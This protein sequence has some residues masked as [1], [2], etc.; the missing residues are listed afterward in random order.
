[1]RAVFHP[2]ASMVSVV[3]ASRAVNSEASPTRPECPVI[4]P[5]MPAAL[6]AAVR[7]RAMDWPFNQPSTGVSAGSGGRSVH[8]AR[9]TPFSRLE[10]VRGGAVRLAPSPVMPY[11]PACGTRRVRVADPQPRVKPRGAAPT[12]SLPPDRLSPRADQRS[13]PAPGSGR[14]P[15][16][17]HQPD[18][19]AEPLP[20]TGRPPHV[21]PA[22]HAR[23]SRRR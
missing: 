21:T 1:M 8:T 5:S 19:T 13:R 20:A 11:A 7:Q 15:R 2:P 16:P 23:W 3:D 18:E 17:G 9:A 6:A 12:R 4:R 22:T 10:H 14:P